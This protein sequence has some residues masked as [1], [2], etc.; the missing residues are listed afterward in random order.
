[1][2]CHGCLF[3][4]PENEITQENVSDTEESTEFIVIDESA[5]QPQHKDDAKV[6][7]VWVRSEVLVLLSCYEH[8][9]NDLNRPVKRRTAWQKIIEEMAAMGVKVQVVQAQNKIKVLLRSYK[10]IKDNSTK[11]GRGALKFEYL[12][13]MDRLFAK[14]KV[15]N[16]TNIA[17]SS[18]KEN[19]PLEHENNSTKTE[20]EASTS[21]K[22][23]INNVSPLR[24]YLDK[25]EAIEVEKK[26]MKQEFF[27][28]WQENEKIKAEQKEQRH[29]E[30]IELE[31]KRI[32]VLEKLL[33]K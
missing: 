20:V 21:K 1:M 26:K 30:R 3:E 24:K 22:R 12:E 27:T 5:Q 9:K 6:A 28:A 2:D 15:I 23:K 25:K 13:E 11:T 32:E 7:K 31:K 18:L 17:S 16:P 19:I 10:K 8:Y 29:K 14:N 33:L 4:L